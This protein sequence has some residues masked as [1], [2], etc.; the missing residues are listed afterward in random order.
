MLR[1]TGLEYYVYAAIDVDRNKIISI[2]VYH[3]RNILAPELSIRENIKT[4]A[5]VSLN[6]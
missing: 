5:R 2:K 3:L 6:P 1:L 4:T